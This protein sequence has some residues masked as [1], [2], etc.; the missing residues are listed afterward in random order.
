M[1]TRRKSSLA[2]SGEHARQALAILVQEGRLRASEVKK[3]LKRRDRLVR[4]LRASL[5]ALETGAVSAGKRL[6]KSFPM[7]R[8]AGTPEAQITARERGDSGATRKK[9]RQQGRFN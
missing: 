1:A 8:A 4:A 5:A 7:A 2:L 6:K 3:A 9:D